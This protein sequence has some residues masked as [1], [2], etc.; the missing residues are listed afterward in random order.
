MKRI[1]TL[2]I[3]IALFGISSF[4]QTIVWKELASLPEGYYSGEAV[5]MNNEIYFVAGRNDKSTTSSFY[6]FSPKT[7][8]WNKLANIPNP[9]TNLALAAVNEKLYAIGGDRFQNTNRE[10]DPQ[11]DTWKLLAPMPTARQHIDCGIYGDKIYITG[12]L[13][14]WKDI[15]KKHEVYDVSKKTWKEKAAIPYIVHNAA[16]VTV[17]S[18]I[19]VIGGAGTKKIFGLMYG[20]LRNTISIPINGHKKK[21]YLNCYLEQ[22]L[23]W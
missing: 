3:F 2:T 9:A 23:L 17:D 21:I 15:T 1:I 10:Y 8:K 20:G 16:V 7:N 4:S 14:S 5:S 12:G 13:T 6:K 18:L 19:Y 22:Q 11:T